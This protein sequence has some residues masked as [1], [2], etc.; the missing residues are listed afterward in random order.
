MGAAFFS[1][2]GSLPL[3]SK[4]RLRSCEEPRAALFSAMPRS[5][6]VIK[7]YGLENPGAVMYTLNVYDFEDAG[8][9]PSRRG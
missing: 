9:A 2:L 6:Y 7:A 3:A 5:V 8:D 4:P 1:K